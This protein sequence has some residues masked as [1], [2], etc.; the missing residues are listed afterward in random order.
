MRRS[1]SPS[2]SSSGSVSASW[3]P[4]GHGASFQRTRA[5]RQ[6]RREAPSARRARRIPRL[7]RN[8][9]EVRPER[10]H[11][12][13]H[14]ARQPHHRRV[15]AR[16]GYDGRAV[17][18]RARAA[19]VSTSE[20]GCARSRASIEC[21]TQRA[22]TTWRSA[23]PRDALHKTNASGR[24]EEAAT[25]RGSSRPSDR[26]GALRRRATVGARQA[27]SLGGARIRN[28][29]PPATRPRSTPCAVALRRTLQAAISST[30]SCAIFIFPPP[31]ADR[32]PRGARAAREDRRDR[33]PAD[34]GEPRASSRATCCASASPSTRAMAGSRSPELRTR[35]FGNAT[36]AD[37][38]D[39]DYAGVSEDEMYASGRETSGERSCSRHARK[40][41]GSSS[42]SRRRRRATP[43]AGRRGRR[44]RPRRAALHARGGDAQHAATLGVGDV[45]ET[46]SLRHA[47]R[48]AFT[49][50]S[51]AGRGK[52]L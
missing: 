26:H 43:R 28:S 10:R 6:H 32:P 12:S 30:I 51:G 16:C 22:R 11:V 3:P 42:R 44:P 40:A 9:R 15:R 24:L 31:P 39:V 27:A 7:A 13:P 1:T 36:A 8:L 50:Q 46:S 19:A 47:E 34:G 29:S 38:P 25:S 14:A 5:P 49:L 35:A 17:R 45:A 48:R 4:P 41:A 52:E 33:R 18:R 20:H 2:S 37:V 21:D 23:G